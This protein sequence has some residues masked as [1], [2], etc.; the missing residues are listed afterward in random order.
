MNKIDVS[1]QGIEGKLSTVTPAAGF[2]QDDCL[3]EMGDYLGGGYYW[4][5]NLRYL[6]LDGRIGGTGTTKTAGCA[7]KMIAANQN[8]L[9]GLHINYMSQRGLWMSGSKVYVDGTPYNPTLYK[10]QFINSN[11]GNTP[12]GVYAD[13]NGN[14]EFNQVFKGAN[15]YITTTQQALHFVNTSSATAQTTLTLDHVFATTSSDGYAV[16]HADISASTMKILLNDSSFEHSTSYL[17]VDLESGS[18]MEA[19]SSYFRSFEVRSGAKM[20]ACGCDLAIVLGKYNSRGCMVFGNLMDVPYGGTFAGWGPPNQPYTKMNG[21]EYV[22]KRYKAAMEGLVWTDDY[23]VEWLCTNAGDN[24]TGQQWIPRYGVVKIPIAY[25]DFGGGLT[26]NLWYSQTN[27]V[28]TDIHFVTGGTGWDGGNATALSIGYTSNQEYFVDANA[29]LGGLG[30]SNLEAYDI[31]TASKN[32]TSVLKTAPKL[33]LGTDNAA[34]DWNNPAL[35]I[36][37]YTDGD[38]TQGES[39]IIIRCEPYAAWPSGT[40]NAYHPD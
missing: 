17:D 1:I 10:V 5:N 30:K 40:H 39:Y 36:S 4:G 37:V 20:V 31:V 38:W 22:N 12:V 23:G 16:L 33:M 27:C 14:T 32:T 7:V 3:I 21:A 34:V 18:Y 9:D 25:T 24:A 11:I 8:I 29:T 26:K 13:N 28:L 6:N 15:L 2:T 19:R 35:G